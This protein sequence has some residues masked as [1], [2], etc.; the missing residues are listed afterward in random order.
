[1]LIIILNL[2]NEFQQNYKMWGFV[3]HLTIFSNELINSTI[4]EHECWIQFSC[5]T[6][7]ALKLHFWHENVK[8]LSKIN[9]IYMH[10]CI[11]L[12]NIKHV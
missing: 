5:D 9:E 7:I 8:S 3:E 6:G 1:M 10:H 2:L 4:I 11:M 12:P